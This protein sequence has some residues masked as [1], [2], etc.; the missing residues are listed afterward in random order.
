MNET[1]RLVLAVMIPLCLLGLY[2]AVR[3]STAR[4]VRAKREWYLANPERFP[5]R[6]TRVLRVLPFM[7]VVAGFTI[8][9]AWS[10]RWEEVPLGVVSVGCFALLMVHAASGRGDPPGA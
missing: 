5:S 1:S 8:W 3:I 6:R 4:Y 9:A 7:L 10:G 2:V